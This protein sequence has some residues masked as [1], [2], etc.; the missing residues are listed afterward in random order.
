M[1]ITLK[2]ARTNS[3]LTQRVAAE[4]LGVAQKTLGNWERGDSFPDAVQIRS[5]E[6]LY[7]VKYDDLVFLPRKTL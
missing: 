3:N 4:K 6:R 7:G 5:L 1:Q 2:A